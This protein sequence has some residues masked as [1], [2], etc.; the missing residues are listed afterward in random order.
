[1]SRA[2]HRQLFEILETLKNAN[3]LI[4]NLLADNAAEEIISLLTDCQNCAIAIG[5]QI[6][7]NYGENLKSIRALEEY[8]EI[9]FQLTEELGDERCQATYLESERQLLKIKANMEAEIP[10]RLEVVFLP[11]KVSMWDSLES[12]WMAADADPNCDAYIIPIPYYDK[13]PDGGFKKEHYEGERYPADVPVM[14]YNDY[15]FKQRHPDMIFI[16]NPYD[17]FNNVT[18]VHPFFYS[19]NLKQFTDLLVY[20]PYYA[21]SGGMSE[22]QSQCMAYY[23]AD[24]IVIQAEKYRKFFDPD[25]PQEKLL[26]F[27]SP[28]FD[29]VIRICNNPPQP[30]FGWKEKMAGKKVYFYNTSINGMLGNT[31]AFLKKMEYVFKCFEG[32]TDSCLIWR[33]HPL[34][35]STF[36]SMRAG[37]KPIYDSLKK[38][39]LESDFGI[40]DDTPEITDTIALCDAYIGDA[41]TSVTSLFGIAGK[42]VFIL[43]NNINSRPEEDDWRGEI[44]KFFYADGN[45]EWLITQ[46]NKLYH[47]PEIN[48]KYE[49]FC[50]LSDYAY[51]DYYSYVVPVNGKNYVCPANAQNILIIGNDGIEKRIELKHCIE[52][53]G[54]FYGAICCGSSLFLIPNNYPA[55]VK[56]NTKTGKIQYIEGYSEIFSGNAEGAKRLGG[57][58]VHNG[59]LFLASPVDNRVLAVHGETGKVQV[60]TTNAKNHCGCVILASD[61]KDLWFLPYSGFVITRWNP[62]SGAVREYDNHPEDLKCKHLVMGYECMEKPFGRGAFYGD[63]LYLPPNYANMYLRLN[64]VTGEITQWYPSCGQPDVVKNGYYASGGK[65]YF[66]RPKGNK[67]RRLY[68]LY[69]SFDRKLY[70]VD[71]ETNEYKEIMIEFPREDLAENEPGFCENSEWLKYACQ[72]NAFNSLSDFLDGNITGNVFDGERQKKAYEEIAA[73]SDGT[74]GVRIYEYLRSKLSGQ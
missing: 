38:Y 16:H 17:Q 47:S 22:G 65:S 1:M 30:P 69:S 46:G 44:I 27:G 53:K 4:E 24:Y 74:S 55:I 18:S 2:V 54:A 21:T 26:P 72:E 37:Y 51:G 40:Y 32:R 34:L 31:A 15:N 58:C 35:E 50:E 39:Y 8:C 19:K 25:L 71:L 45:D 70:E 61:G 29:K 63:Y 66:Y 28:K 6:E 36:T 48:Y 14:H 5:T 62:E 13:N 9:A 33:P 73:N 56:Y 3:H 7:N 20:V 11:Y 68:H 60:L 64:K 12:I 43:N 57:Y 67:D 59:Y 49:Y 41:G 42:P 10:D 52:Q 23:Y